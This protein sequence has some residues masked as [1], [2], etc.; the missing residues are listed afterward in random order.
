MTTPHLEHALLEG[1]VSSVVVGLA[2]FYIVGLVYHILH[3]KQ[4]K[5]YC[6]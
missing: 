6:N 4:P 5:W 3:I 1:M 2:M